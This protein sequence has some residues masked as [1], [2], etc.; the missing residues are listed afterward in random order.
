LRERERERERERVSGAKPSASSREDGW[1][2]LE[3]NE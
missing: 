1:M 3:V 2:A